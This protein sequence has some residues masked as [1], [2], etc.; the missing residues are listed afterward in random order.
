MRR[1]PFLVGKAEV[2]IAAGAGRRDLADTEALA[3]AA[4]LALERVHAGARLGEL[5][6]D[7]VTP[8]QR[9]R[10]HRA[11]VAHEDAGL[12]YPVGERL[13][14][15][16][17]PAFRTGLR[18]QCRPLVQAVEILADH[19]RVVEGAVVRRGQRR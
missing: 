17:A 2:E 4:A 7:P 13:Q 9:L 11:L 3:P 12:E 6:S 8:L 1:A 10:P 16:F 15:Q 18:E 5:A 19:R 14:P